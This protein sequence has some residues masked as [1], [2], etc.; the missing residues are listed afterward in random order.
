MSARPGAPAFKRM[1]AFPRRCQSGG[2]RQ[3]YQCRR[4]VAGNA[5]EQRDA[6]PSTLTDPH[7]RTPVA[8]E[9]GLERVVL[10]AVGTCWRRR[11]VRGGSPLRASRAPG[12]CEKRSSAPAWREAAPEHLRIARVADGRALEIGDL[13][14]PTINASGWALATARALASASRTAVSAGASS[15][16]ADSSIAG[17]ATVNGRPSRSSSALRYGEVEARTSARVPRG[18]VV[19]FT[20]FFD[21]QGQA[22]YYATFVLACSGRAMLRRS[23]TRRRTRC[24]PD[25]KANPDG[26]SDD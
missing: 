14:G 17:A 1:N 22:R 7:N 18:E 4:I 25:Q 3:A 16:R 9:V 15:S 10:Q 19:V 5:G 12:R 21:T 24:L 13:V 8:L 23:A 20:V 11:P 26:D 6:E 2:S